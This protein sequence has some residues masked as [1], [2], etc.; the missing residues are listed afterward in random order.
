MWNQ[1]IGTEVQ[2]LTAKNNVANAEDQLKAA[3]ENA[4]VVLEQLNTTSVTSDVDGVADQV[5]VK[6]GELFGS[7]G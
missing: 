5:T 3:Q 1:N 4:K 2:L 7:H 6:V